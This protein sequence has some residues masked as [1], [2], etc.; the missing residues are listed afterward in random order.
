LKV[1]RSRLAERDAMGEAHVV[2]AR[3]KKPLV[4]PVVAE[5]ALLGNAPAP[6][7]VNRFIRACVDALLASHTPIEIHHD[8]PIRPFRD[9]SFGAGICAG[10]LFTVPAHPDVKPEAQFAVGR[11]QPFLKNGDELHPLGGLHLLLAGD[12]TGPATPAG[13]VINGE[14][15]VLHDWPPSCFSGEILHNR[16]LM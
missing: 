13:F 11:M 16:V 8:D 15:R 14:H 2:G 1:R 9:G 5:V 12:F 6:I 4:H 3:R 10:R 7:V